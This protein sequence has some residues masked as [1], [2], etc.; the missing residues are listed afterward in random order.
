MP[1]LHFEPGDAPQRGPADAPVLV[2][3]FADFRCPYCARMAPV[4]ERLLA[5]YPEDVRL[6]FVH[7]PV[8]SPDSGRAAVAAE[9][10]RR[11]G[12]FWAMHDAL[13]QL[14]GHPLDEAE[15]RSVVQGLGLD[16][17]RFSRDLRDPQLLERVR[18]DRARGVRLGVDAT[19]AFLVN[20]RLLLG[21]HRFETLSRVVESEIDA[22]R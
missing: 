6:A 11:Q 4:V 9:A 10:A 22:M 17:Q 12:A 21:V 5:A 7:M 16:P 20:G 15:L 8:V 2:V 19:P 13:Y 18:A 1:R 3:E 14:Q